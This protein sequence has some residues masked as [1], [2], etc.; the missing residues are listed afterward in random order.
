MKGG[1][2][3][4]I[5]PHQQAGNL[6]GYA[7]LKN[8]AD[9]R[10]TRESRLEKAFDLAC[11]ILG[12][13]ELGSQVAM[14]SVL[15][16]ETVARA[17]DRRFY[18][19]P[20]GRGG[21]SQGNGIRARNLIIL[22][23]H[24]LLQSIIYD[25]TEKH[26][27]L[28][29][30]SQKSIDEKRFLVHFIKHL[31]KITLKHNSFYVTLGLSRLLFNY[32]TAE[33][34]E[35]YNLIIQDPSR[36]KDD[37]Y[38]RSRKARLMNQIKERFGPLLRVT[39]VSKG[40]ERFVSDPESADKYQLVR[41]SLEMFMP[42]GSGCPLGPSPIN[43]EI[44]N[45]TFRGGDPDDEHG[46]EISRIHALMHGECFERIIAGLNYDPPIERLELPRFFNDDDR[47]DRKQVEANMEQREIKE[48]SRR[49]DEYHGTRDQA[50]PEELRILVNG[51]EYC[52]LSPVESKRIDLDLDDD[53]DMIE[54]RTVP[55]EGN[56]LLA[57]HY[58][59]YGILTTAK[60]PIEYSTRLKRGQK[61]TFFVEPA[62]ESVDERLHFRIGVGY[63]E[64]NPLRA[65][66]LE[67]RK[68]SRMVGAS[69]PGLSQALRFALP[70]A[71]AAVTIGG[72]WLY[73]DQMDR[74]DESFIA[75]NEEP[76]KDILPPIQAPVGETNKAQTKDT[77]PPRSAGR[78]RVPGSVPTVTTR[79]AGTAIARS[80][81][82]IRSIFVK[83]TGQSEEEQQIAELIDRELRA[84][85]RW[86][87][88]TGDDADAALLV[89]T[90]NGNDRIRVRLIDENAETIWPIK[91]PR[92]YSGTTEEIARRIVADL[93][94]GK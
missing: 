81:S 89:E 54:V 26:E 13:G 36:V 44:E 79:S 53:A 62:R 61:V 75:T 27:K 88:A 64:T 33:A 21:G 9:I 8:D 38:W 30:S 46:I 59:D 67:W 65:V 55:E 56:L 60:E 16:L 25:E 28:I 58:I 82:E 24:H 19:T 39:R 23:E 84:A 86:E 11:F 10:R 1:Y 12:D 93:L 71:M 76:V 3:P 80:L 72:V 68:L 42:W 32:S 69:D 70:A 29:E 87:I 94:V 37:Y 85:G 77:A 83:I 2:A 35:I 22:N 31:V 90:L 92:I 74:Q 43:G 5:P 91:G 15:R 66:R 45:L 6:Q 63:R 57:T 78:T 73:I 20:T 34:A 48:L 40:E 14:N 7:S 47:G 4:V 17:Q 49:I 50:D 41:E 51:Q 18:Y 52:T